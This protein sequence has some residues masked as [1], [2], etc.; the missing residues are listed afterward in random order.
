MANEKQLI[1]VLTEPTIVLDDLESIDTETGTADAI[2]N[3]VTPVSLSKQF[4]AVVPLIQVLNFSFEGETIVSFSLNSTGDIP[5]A[6]FTVNVRDKSFYSTSFPKDG[7]LFSIFIR[8]KDDLF[9]PIH[10]D[11]EI[12]GV[13]ITPTQNEN[14]TETMTISGKLRIPGYDAIKCFSVKGTSM[15][16]MMKVATDLNLGFAS[17]EVDTD[18]SQVWICPY[19]KVKDFIADTVAA[20][21]KDENSFFSYFIDWYYYFNFVNVEPLFSE[22][23]E[24]DEG[25]MVSMLGNDYGKDSELPKELTKNVLSN[26]DEVQMQPN[27]IITHNLTNKSAAVN[28]RHGYKRY[29]QFY[30]ALIKENQAIFADP[31]TTEGAE[32]EKQLLKGR[33]AEEFYLQQIEGKWM[34]VQYGDNGDNCHGNYNY[35]KILN[36]QNIVH[37]DKMGIEIVLQGLNFNLR[38]MQVVPV[39]IAIKRDY[40]RKRFNEPVDEDQQASNPNSD[41][42]NRTKSALDFE[43]TPITIDKVASGFYV[44][45]SM[46]IVFTEGKFQHHCTLIRREWPTPPQTY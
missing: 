43:D 22:Q 27:F 23:P 15:N 30:D 46:R 8:S 38:R 19:D 20:S 37:M 14:T 13:K 18:D 16:A 31:Y 39:V 4:G 17:N 26:W 40:V 5:T 32:R 9:K 3:P 35:S 44:I 42:P 7:D 41:E 10:N 24:I 21:Y 25:M 34:G 28:L 1:R 45:N 6:S 11:Y 12:T 36:F 29:A 2:G 33:P